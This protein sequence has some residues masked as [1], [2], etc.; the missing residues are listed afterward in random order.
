MCQTQGPLDK[1]DH[2]LN[3]FGPQEDAKTIMYLVY[4]SIVYSSN[5]SPSWVNPHK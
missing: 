4:N 1:F 3:L 2:Q 5:L